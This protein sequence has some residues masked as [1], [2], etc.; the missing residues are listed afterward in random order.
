MERRARS[1]PHRQAA[2]RLRR[3]HPGV[4]ERRPA[5]RA[6]RRAD[7]RPCD[8]RRPPAPPVA[9]GAAAARRRIPWRA[10]AGEL[11]DEV[12]GEGVPCAMVTMSWTQLA[13]AVAEQLPPRTF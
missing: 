7:A 5:G 10:G 4:R 1:R 8:G 11:L 9:A 3:V 13:D 2:A 6:D 12:V